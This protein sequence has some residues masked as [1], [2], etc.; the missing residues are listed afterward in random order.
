MGG[1]PQGERRESAPPRSPQK[2]ELL[3]LPPLALQG[4]LVSKRTHISVFTQ[5]C[6]G[7]AEFVPSKEACRK[8]SLFVPCL[9]AASGHRAQYSE[10][11][12]G[13]PR[14]AGPPSTLHGGLESP[15]KCVSVGPVYNRKRGTESILETLV[16]V[17]GHGVKNILS[18]ENSDNR[19]VPHGL[20]S[21]HG[22][23]LIIG[24][25]GENIISPG[26]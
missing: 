17:P 23:R 16:P 22:R 7:P 6:C 13:Q 5:V 8:I 18:S 3:T 24:S 26:T 15:S 12:R 10:Y 21:G 4:A 20:G 11:S 2:I 19:C 9:P 1:P 14:E 25:C